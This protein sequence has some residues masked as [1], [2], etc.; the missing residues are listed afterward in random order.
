M[1]R[2]DTST[3]G[4]I[5][6]FCLEGKSRVTAMIKMCR[7]RVRDGTFD[8]QSEKLLLS[9]LRRHPSFLQVMGDLPP[10]AMYLDW[11]AAPPPNAGSHCLCVRSFADPSRRIDLERVVAVGHVAFHLGALTPRRALRAGS[12]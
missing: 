3:E 7:D 1:V 9:I 5:D 4:L 11:A 8:K 2:D 12:R 10:E 6:L